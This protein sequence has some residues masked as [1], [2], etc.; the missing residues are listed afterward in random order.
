MLILSKEDRE[1]LKQA[2]REAVWQILDAEIFPL[3][4]DFA[5]TRH[6]AERIPPSPGKNESVPDVPES[7]FSSL[8]FE[9]QKGEKLGPYEAAFKG[10]NSPEPWQ[11]CYDILK[12]AKATIRDSY[13]PAGFIYR[14]WIYETQ[15]FENRVFRKKLEVT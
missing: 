2:A 12:E 13:H 9:E 3:L 1:L 14:Y 7:T 11:R 4:R 8:K 15:G 10:A 5:A 6:D